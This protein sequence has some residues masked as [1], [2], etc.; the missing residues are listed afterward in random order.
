MA[1]EHRR[2]RA[3]WLRRRPSGHGLSRTLS[4]LLSLL[5]LTRVPVASAHGSTATGGL[6]QGHGVVLAVL[7][8]GLLVGASALKR[9]DRLSPT[10]A[11]YGAFLG[12]VLTALGAVL[13]E[14]LSPE[15]TYSAQSMPFPRSWYPAL[16]LSVGFFI[17]VSSLVVGRL[18]WPTRPR[19]T[20][21]GIVMG[22]WVAYPYLI[23]GAASDSHPL[24]YAI[25]LGTPMLVGYIVWKDAREVLRSVFRDPVAR[26]FG[27][28]VGVVLALFFVSVTGYVSFFPEEGLPHE[29][30][31]TVLPAVYQLVTWP[32]LEIYLPHI[33]LFVAISPG[34]LVVVG[35]LSALVG[36]NAALIARH[37]RME[38]RA[39]LTEGAAG[40]A[41][42]VGS[43]TCGCCGPLIAKVAVLAAGPSIAAPLY[44]VFVDSAS[45][46]SS[47][48]I[49]GSVVLFAGSIVYSVE[50]ARRPVGSTSAV[51]AD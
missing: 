16:S 20:F 12:I 19:Y 21:L 42:I 31:V 35:L 32:I 28:G 43:C 1:L 44:W 7:G 4:V 9:R 11:L 3:G 24:G 2:T 25:V 34:Q 13:F 29:P 33:P 49:V 18:R 50:S 15:P 46:L 48:F 22:L 39:G 27:V 51:S 36:L 6:S 37:W 45:P 40:G 17:M 38:E 8:V 10:T 14:G 5:V 47:L 30:F 23:R 26:R 41:A